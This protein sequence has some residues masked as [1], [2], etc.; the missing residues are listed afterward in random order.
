MISYPGLPVAVCRR[1]LGRRVQRDGCGIAPAVA[2]VQGHSLPAA[3]RASGFR[4]K[5]LGDEMANGPPRDASGGHLAYVDG[6]ET[7]LGR[8]RQERS[9]HRSIKTTFQ[10]WW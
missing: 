7:A 3:F 10:Q 4:P 2:S 1:Y 5:P 9:A 8:I 6:S